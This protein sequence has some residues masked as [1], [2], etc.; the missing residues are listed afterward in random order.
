MKETCFVAVDFAMVI[1]HTH[2]HTRTHKHTH[3]HT[4]KH[5]HAVFRRVDA[6]EKAR[7]ST[8]LRKGA[9]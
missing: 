4:H 9:F 5:T 7:K 6:G 2:T 3:T 8:E 1:T